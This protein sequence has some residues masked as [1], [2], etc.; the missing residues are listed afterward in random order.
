MAFCWRADD[1]LLLVQE[2]DHPYSHQLKQIQK[3]NVVK[4]GPPLTK[5]SGS[6]HDWDVK[7]QLK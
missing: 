3:K 6:A 4:V 5:V 1:G 2:F 7:Y